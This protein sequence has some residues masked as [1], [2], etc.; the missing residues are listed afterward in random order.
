LHHPVRRGEAHGFLNLLAA[1]LWPDAAEEALADEDMAECLEPGRGFRWHGR[2]AG[3]AEVAAMRRER[4][5][6]F[7][8]CSVAEPVE[9]LRA[10]GIL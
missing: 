3:A 6:S 9:G 2:E 1:A 8:S 5:R 7:G 10:L 4:F